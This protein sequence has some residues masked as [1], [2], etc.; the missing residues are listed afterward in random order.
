MDLKKHLIS[1]L[2]ENGLE[3]LEEKGIK[4]SSDERYNL[5]NLKYGSLLA[6]KSDPIV[7]ACR[8]ALVEL[9]PETGD[10]SLVGYAF[11]RFF[12]LGESQAAPINWSKARFYEK[13]DGSLI[14]LVNWGGEWIVSTS[15]SVAGAGQVGDTGRSF[16]ELF[17]HV[18]DSLYSR[19][20]LDT[21]ICYVFELCHKDNRIVVDYKEPQLP[22]LAVRDRSKELEELDLEQFANQT[23]FKAA[24]S[25]NLCENSVF[26]FVN[27]R[28]A[29]HEGLIVFDGENRVKI[30]SE[31]YVHLHKVRGNKEPDFSELYLSG[32]LDEFLS[33]FPEYSNRFNDLRLKLE[34]A[35]GIV[36]DI[37]EQGSKM[38]QKQFALRVVSMFP[39]LSGAMFGVRSGK[40]AN[41]SHYVSTLKPQQLDKILQSSNG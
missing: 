9:S 24:P 2:N 17:W 27:S 29:G 8:G 20:W 22:L 34:R 12:N 1:W 38:D 37:V 13:M 15:G 35:G 26:N 14:K 30:K 39:S 4:I 32:D 41:F 7:C 16:S 18:F 11:D 33:Y 23:G 10:F 21:N 25:Y 19:D 3:P 36:A 5:Y 28:G 31:I 6:D 40:Y